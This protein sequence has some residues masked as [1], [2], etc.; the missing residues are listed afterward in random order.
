MRDDVR[1]SP[2]DRV[3][4]DERPNTLCTGRYDLP[5]LGLRSRCHDRICRMR[6]S[7]PLHEGRYTDIAR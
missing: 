1:I 4:L 7:E 5:L 6:R 3:R 2:L